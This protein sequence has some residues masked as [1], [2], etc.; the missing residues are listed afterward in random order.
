MIL[1]TLIYV[2]VA[3]TA[4]SVLGWEAL[5]KSAHPLDEVAARA[6]PWF[7]GIDKVFFAVTIFAIGNTA[8]LNYLM[9]SRLLYGM[10]TQGLLPPVISRIH[11]RRHTP[12]VAIGCLFIIVAAL[13][14]AGGVK[15]MAE[16]TVLLLLAVFAL[17]NAALV[18]LKRRPGE[19]RGGFEIPALIPALGALV[20]AVL[21]GNRLYQAVI[22]K[23]DAT[24]TAPL[25]ALAIL[26]AGILI[27]V[28]RGR[29][30]V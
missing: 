14:S 17:M 28:F 8:L 13:I 3:I 10:G 20:C 7:T 30:A 23:D 25:V 1:A 4:V 27:G 18:V 11:P 15:A 12:H 6:A 21:F 22:S 2:A 19:E 16:A 26:T 5:S 29:R 9:G 24:R